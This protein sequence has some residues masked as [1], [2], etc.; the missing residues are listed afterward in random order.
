MLTKKYLPFYIL[1]TLLVLFALSGCDLFLKPQETPGA[2]QQVGVAPTDASADLLAT[3][4]QPPTE[5][6]PPTDTQVPTETLEPT[7]TPPPTRTSAPTATFTLTVPPTVDNPI[8]VYY[9]NLDVAGRYGCGEALYYVYTK[10]ARSDNIKNDIIYALQRLFSFHGEYF[11]E[12]YNPYGAS[13]F[14]IGDVETTEEQ[15]FIVYLTGTYVPSDD[16][17]DATRLAD[18]IRMTILQFPQVNSVKIYL[19]GASIGDAL[20]RK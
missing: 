19:N 13:N 8:L 6:P 1:L 20:K 11:G 15:S 10:Q 14:A 18:Q 7:R 5:L 9:F 12:L 17:C 16:P 2:T 3:P 4:T